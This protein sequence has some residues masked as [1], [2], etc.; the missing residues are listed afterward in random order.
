MKC[1]LMIS[2]ITICLVLFTNCSKENDVIND[3]IVYGTVT[4]IDGNTYKTV[5]IGSQVWMAENLRT[6]KFNDGTSIPLVSNSIE[7]QNNKSYGYCWYENNQDKYENVFGV[8]YNW[9]TV[10]VAN[11]GNKSVSPAGWH[12]PTN[13]DWKILSDYLGGREVAGGKL[14]ARGTK[15]WKSPNVGATNET[16]FSALPGGFR[17]NQGEFFGFGERFGL[18]WS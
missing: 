6:T 5:T 8:L 18:W 14:K 11:N 10:D 16:G 15:Y 2:F 12:V 7:W 9:H 4:D 1:S 3:N 17:D 13:E